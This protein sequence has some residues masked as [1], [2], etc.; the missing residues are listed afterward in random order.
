MITRGNKGSASVIME[1]ADYRK[2][3]ETML[4]DADTYLK[5]KKNPT[6]DYQQ[7]FNTLID[8]WKKLRYIDK[9]TAKR[10]KCTSGSIPKFY[11]FP[12]A[13]KEGFPL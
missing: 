9:I 2:K 8:F 12:K 4:A 6:L 1:K 13:H 11:A 7:K 10:L 3:A 5:L